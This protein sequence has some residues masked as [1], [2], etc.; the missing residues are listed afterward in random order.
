MLHS[1][2]TVLHSRRSTVQLLQPQV[3]SAVSSPSA[4]GPDKLQQ[5]HHK[6]KHIQVAAPPLQQDTHFGEGI[7]FLLVDSLLDMPEG[8][9]QAS[10]VARTAAAAACSPAADHG[11]TPLGLRHTYPVG[12][13]EVAV[14]M[15]NLS[16][17]LDSL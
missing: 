5:G 1:R 15:Q 8:T 2:Q 6:H 3:G 7:H 16:L 17:V 10:P 14:D 12:V 13:S 4:Q 9:L 11:Y